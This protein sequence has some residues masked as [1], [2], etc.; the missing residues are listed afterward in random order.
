MVI[1]PRPKDGEWGHIDLASGKPV[2][3]AGEGQY[4]GGSFK[5]LDNSS[6][7]YQPMGKSAQEAALKAFKD[8]GY[9]VREGAYVEK[10]YDFATGKWVPKT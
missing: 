8:A 5:M 4:S 9:A 10:M 1:T 6:G 3:A 2:I 7:H